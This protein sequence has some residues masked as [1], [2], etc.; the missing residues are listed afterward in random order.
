MLNVILQ[1]LFLTFLQKLLN[2]VEHFCKKHRKVYSDKK[3]P[4]QIKRCW[5][6]TK[7]LFLAMFS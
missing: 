7:Q 5:N 1:N 6:C 3:I 4:R 2:A